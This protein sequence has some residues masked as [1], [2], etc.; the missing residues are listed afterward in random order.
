MRGAIPLLWIGLLLLAP[1]PAAAIDRQVCDACRRV[2]LDSPC[3]MSFALDKGEERGRGYSCSPTCMFE[4]AEDYPDYKLTDM[5]VVRWPDREELQ[6]MLYKAEE[7]AWLL[8]TKG[9]HA[10]TH[11][12]YCAAFASQEEAKAAQKELG[13]TVCGWKKVKAVCFKTAQSE[14]VNRTAA[15][16]RLR[17]LE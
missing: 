15:G 12:P 1:P 8:D 10:H 17:L 13:G 2:W 11:P 9:K 3:R 14:D 16:G 4:V 7:C 5:R 6:A